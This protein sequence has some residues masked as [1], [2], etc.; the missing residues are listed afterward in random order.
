MNA[1]ATESHADRALARWQALQTDARV[2]DAFAHPAA[3]RAYARLAVAF[4]TPPRAC[5]K[6]GVAHAAAAHAR[7]GHTVTHPKESLAKNEL[8]DPCAKPPLAHVEL[9]A[10]HPEEAPP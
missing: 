10:T 2:A 1:H 5:A 9:A 4:P 7:A 6:E 8:A 3:P